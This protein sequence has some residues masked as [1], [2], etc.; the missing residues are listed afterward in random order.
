MKRK[1]LAWLLVPAAAVSIAV[2]SFLTKES[3][4]RDFGRLDLFNQRN[5]EGY[6]VDIDEDSLLVGSSIGIGNFNF[7]VLRV[8]LGNRVYKRLIYP[9]PSSLY[10]GDRIKGTYEPVGKKISYEELAEKCIGECIDFVQKGYIE[11]EGIIDTEKI[12]TTKLWRR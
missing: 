3:K 8:D 2:G 7:E 1:N 4:A 12:E 11:T 5:F 6:V 9:G 10:E